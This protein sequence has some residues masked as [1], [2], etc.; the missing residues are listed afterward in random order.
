ME[1]DLKSMFLAT[2]AVAREMTTR[3][4][5]SIV[6][7]SSIAGL[8]AYRRTAYAAAKAGVIGFVRSVAGQV[9]AQGVRIN[10]IAPGL[11]WT[12]MVENLGPEMRERRRAASLLGTEG[13]GWDV[14][15]SA[16]FLASDESRWITGQTIVVDAGLTLTTR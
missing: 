14:A 1:V 10:A 6:C 16:V 3:G 2:R 4:R 11:V 12:P 15:W 9:G 13:T 8:R 7:V 5:G